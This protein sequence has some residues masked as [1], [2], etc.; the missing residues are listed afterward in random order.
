MAWGV[1]DVGDS[2]IGGECGPCGE[3][4]LHESAAPA[5]VEGSTC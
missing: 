4:S 2:D 1:D 5:A 3:G